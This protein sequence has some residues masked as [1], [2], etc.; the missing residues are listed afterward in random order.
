[1]RFARTLLILV[2][3]GSAPDRPGLATGPE[4]PKPSKP[5]EA[6]PPD[7]AASAPSPLFLFLNPPADRETFLK[8]LA[9]PDRVILDGEAY[10]KLRQQAESARPPLANPSM[11]V[12]SLK[13]S[14]DVAGDWA[15]ISVEFRINLEQDGPTWV[16]IHLDGMTLSEAREGSKD[17]PGPDDRRAILAG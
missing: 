1:M 4:D 2:L 17:L 15:R 9:K 12:E 10:R 16:P 8:W 6:R 5:A 7:L 14:G 3:L 13:A 11:V